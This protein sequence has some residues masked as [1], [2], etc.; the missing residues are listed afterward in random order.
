M[1]GADGSVRHDGYEH[2]ILLV[3]DIESN[4]LVAGS[5]LE[6]FGY[7]YDVANDGKQALDK[8]RQKKYAVVLMDIQMPVING[9][10]ATKA[11]R[12]I[13]AQD[14]GRRLPIIGMTAH[15]LSGD[16]VK[17]LE[18]CIDYYIS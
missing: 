5:F 12:S 18:A 16:R 9:F 17:C 2:P 15:A 7:S 14:N 13:E 11:I 6:K 1:D 3:E 8:I 4:V 10:E